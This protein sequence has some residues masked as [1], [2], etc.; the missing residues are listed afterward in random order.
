MAASLFFTLVN[1][2]LGLSAVEPNARAY[3]Y[4]NGTSTPITVYTDAAH[5]VPYG[6][7]VQAD[8][9]GQFPPVYY[10]GTAPYRLLLTG[11][12]G[13][14]LPGFPQDDVPPIALD[15][16]SAAS[17]PFT[18]TETVPATNVQD[19]IVAVSGLYADQGSILDRALTPWVTG[20]TGDA[21]TVT[22]DPAITGYGTFLPLRVRFNRRNTGA[23]TLNVNGLGVRNIFKMQRTGTPTALG[24]DDIQPGDVLDL[25]YDG[26]QFTIVGTLPGLATGVTR[27][28]SGV[29]ICQT[30]ATFTYNTTTS[31]SYTWTFGAT[32][33]ATPNIHL[34]MPNTVLGAYTGVDGRNI[35]TMDQG[36]GETASVLR[37]LTLPG[38]ASLAPGAQI[39]NVGLT[40][41]GRWF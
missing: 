19:A 7:Y 25:T 27:M 39:T 31:L 15:I 16:T 10:Q 36:S 13:V 24:P 21:Y 22:P 41:I 26:A 2:A 6:A 18:P 12:T 30:R 1:R 38:S 32:F 20:G 35:I 28:P 4:A 8:A 3:F 29:Q 37:L 40:A 11:A 33:S 34:S 9:Y 14:P 23:A 5:L 17:I